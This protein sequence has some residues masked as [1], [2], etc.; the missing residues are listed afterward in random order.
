MVSGQPTP[1]PPNGMVGTGP[2]HR[3]WCV[4]SPTPVVPRPLKPLVFLCFSIGSTKS[5]IMASQC[6]G[7]EDIR[8]H[9]RTFENH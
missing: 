3:L 8:E 2:P 6:D 9:W 7:G 5:T 1:P 4:G